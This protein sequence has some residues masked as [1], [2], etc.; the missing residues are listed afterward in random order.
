MTGVIT[1]T[2]KRNSFL[3]ILQDIEYLHGQLFE[4]T[5][6]SGC[7]SVTCLPGALTMLRYSA[8]R[9]VAK[10]YFAEEAGKYSD[11][12]DFSKCHL[13]EDRWLTHLFMVAAQ[14]PH[15]L[16]MCT[17]A[18]CKTEAV[19]TFK[20]LLKQRRRWFLGFITNEV[21]LL[22]DLRCWRRYPLL[23]L[24]RL[25]HNTIRTTSLLFFIM[26]LSV[27]TTANKIGSLPVGFI[28]VVLGLNYAL[29]FY[30]GIRLRRLKAWL[31][32]IMFVVNPFFNWM[33]TVY[34]MFTAGS[35]TWG[36]PRADA[37]VADAT[38]TAREVIERA[39]QVGDDLNIVPESFRPAAQTMA[40]GH[41]TMPSPVALHPTDRVEGRFGVPERDSGGSY[42]TSRESLV[43]LPDHLVRHSEIPPFILSRSSSSSTIASSPWG[44][45]LVRP[46]KDLEA[47]YLELGSP[48]SVTKLLGAFEEVGL[49]SAERP[50]D[51]SPVAGPS[52]LPPRFG[53]PRTPI[54]TDNDGEM[55]GSPDR[56]AR[57]SS[58]GV[59]LIIEPASSGGVNLA[60]AQRTPVGPG[61]RPFS[62]RQ[63]TLP[64]SPLGRASFER[65]ATSPM[66]E[67][68]Q[69][70]GDAAVEMIEPGLR[71]ASSQSSRRSSRLLQVPK[72]FL[73]KNMN[74]LRR[75]TS[76]SGNDKDVERGDGNGDGGASGST[77]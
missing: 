57:G 50:S 15:Q 43:T 10:Y 17:G 16:Q 56:L 46:Q 4:R 61:G 22:T 2:T 27:L 25:M 33:Y 9:R 52:T 29:M 45:E 73:R 51:Q 37:G 23:C 62:M 18:F 60:H 67:S 65:R 31:Y 26:I 74:K 72:K 39:D 35:R 54:M 5:V 30:F 8:F 44:G 42:T 63:H 41:G 7:G 66:L 77:S 64:R 20:H 47:G 1:S 36:G 55:S 12:F 53:T 38:T 21:C 69:N 48:Q 49:D 14:K 58:Q 70:Q 75:G 59:P 11:M 3:T 40:Y 24:L 13:G 34:G 19:E 71:R 76:K 28:A 6:E 68:D 32:V